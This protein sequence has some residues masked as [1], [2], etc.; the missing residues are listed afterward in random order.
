VRPLCV[1]C[2][3]RPIKAKEVTCPEC[4]KDVAA[5][6]K[7]AESKNQLEFFD[8]QKKNDVSFRHMIRKYQSE[9][10]SRGAGKSRL[11]FD[12]AQFVEAIFTQSEDY[13]DHQGEWLDFAAF[14][15]YQVYS[16]MKKPEEADTLWKAELAKPGAIR[17]MKGAEEGFPERILLKTHEFV[18]IKNG[19]GTRQEAQRGTKPTKGLQAVKAQGLNEANLGTGHISF[20]SEFHSHI[21]GAFAKASGVHGAFS[22]PSQVALPKAKVEKSTAASSPGEE[23]T[24]GDGA[25]RRK[26]VDVG[27]YRLKVHEKSEAVKS[28]VIEEITKTLQDAAECMKEIP[29]GDG[30]LRFK[31]FLETRLKVVEALKTD[32]TLKPLLASLSEKQKMLVPCSDTAVLQSMAGVDIHLVA[33]LGA[34]TLDE[35]DAAKSFFDDSMKIVRQLL[36]SVTS[37]CKDC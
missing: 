15:A 10:P 30:F 14:V 1:V 28:S 31:E 18:G 8:S 29:Q 37:A 7:D 2:V 34:G 3:D 22:A 9:C 21:G 26:K 35:I 6:R 20:Q 19:S 36:L 12:W 13:N 5:A 33:I 4:N 23:D 25:K 24:G 11:V 16:R 27:L 17:D 32:E